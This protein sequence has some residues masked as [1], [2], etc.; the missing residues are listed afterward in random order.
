MTQS[1]YNCLHYTNVLPVIPKEHTECHCSN[2]MKGIT[3]DFKGITES[4]IH[5]KAER[6]LN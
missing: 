1:K 5:H 6:G 3:P 4:G 2:I